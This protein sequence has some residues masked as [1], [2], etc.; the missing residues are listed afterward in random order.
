[1]TEPAERVVPLNPLSLATEIDAMDVERRVAFSRVLLRV[2]AARG[3]SSEDV[4]EEAAL[5]LSSLQRGNLDAL[6]TLIG[7]A[8]RNMGIIAQACEEFTKDAH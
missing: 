7:Y 6:R 3:E 2:F 8:Q 5:S 1:M 4:L